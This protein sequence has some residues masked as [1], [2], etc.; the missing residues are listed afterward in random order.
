MGKG[1][2]VIRTL[3]TGLYGVLGRGGGCLVGMAASIVRLLL[4]E[5]V[6]ATVVWVCLWRQGLVAAG[7]LL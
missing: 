1:L 6:A 4:G 5:A 3:L 7:Q 2:G